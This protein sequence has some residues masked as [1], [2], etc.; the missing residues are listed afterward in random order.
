MQIVGQMNSFHRS[1]NLDALG[2]EAWV[3]HRLSEVNVTK[4]SRALCHV[5]ST[6]L[7]PVPKYCYK[8]HQFLGLCEGEIWI[9]SIVIRH[10]LVY[11]LGLN[12][13]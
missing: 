11:F 13:D 6:C 4:V 2:H 10:K 9:S 3:K 1:Y 8:S 7:T 12:L 5:P